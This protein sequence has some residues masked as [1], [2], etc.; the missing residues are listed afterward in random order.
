MSEHEAEQPQLPLVGIGPRLKAA[1]EAA[2]ISRAG[3][4]QKTRIAE[5]LIAEIEVGNWDAMPSRTYATG[6][7]R[8]YARTVGLNE[9]EIVAGVRREMGLAD[10]VEHRAATAALEPG[11]PARIPGSKFAWWLALLALVVAIS[12]F[13]AWR[14]LYSPAMTL[15][16]VLPEET[17]SAETIVTTEATIPAIDA[18]LTPSATSAPDLTA[19]QPNR[20]SATPRS[21]PRRNSAPAPRPTA[22]PAQT[23]PP[24]AVESPATAAQSPSTVSN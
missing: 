24:P 6:F 5:R 14:S 20:P 19:V 18:S 21:E 2:G 7:T 22:T 15:P 23:A 4:A 16:E 12:G 10:P 17:A 1:R 11:D 9:A 3:I 8:T 13:F